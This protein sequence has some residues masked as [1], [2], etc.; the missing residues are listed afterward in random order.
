MTDAAVHS[1]S[2]KS[3][4]FQELSLWAWAALFL[5][6]LITRIDLSSLSDVLLSLSSV[7]LIVLFAFLVAF[8]AL[9]DS[10]RDRPVT[11]A[12]LLGFGVLMAGTLF[13]GLI[14]PQ[15]LIG[16]PI[17]AFGLWLIYRRGND[18]KL[19]AAGITLLAISIHLFW[20]RMLFAFFIPEFLAL[21]AAVVSVIVPL[22]QPEV[23]M[24]GTSFHSVDGHAIMLVGAC[25][26][27]NNI[28]LALLAG[29]SAIVFARGRIRFSDWPWMLAL[30][31]AMIAMNVVRLSLMAVDFESYVYWHEADGIIILQW[32]QLLV[33]GGICV[34]AALSDRSGKAA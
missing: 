20:G 27:F 30:T 4:R 8:N 15:A 12:D 31:I 17:M 16:L 32:A 22:I 7:N 23:A 19:F 33:L 6:F 28:S 29:A 9:L 25:S 21:D 10:D 2:L 5:N 18:E 3:P 1:P 26:S 11:R 14:G 13:E 34:L 24:Q